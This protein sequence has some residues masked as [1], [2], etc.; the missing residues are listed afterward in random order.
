M[1]T[2]CGVALVACLM[3]F[4]GCAAIKNGSDCGNRWNGFCN[5][6][7]CGGGSG[8]RGGGFHLPSLGLNRGELLGR[9]AAAC[10]DGANANFSDY[11]YD[12]GPM[13]GAY[14]DSAQ[15]SNGCGCDSCEVG[16]SYVAGQWKSWMGNGVTVPR[17]FGGALAARAEGAAALLGSCRGLGATVGCMGCRECGGSNAIGTNHSDCSNSSG[18]CDTGCGPDGCGAIG[19]GAGLAGRVK[20]F[21]FRPN[22]SPHPYGGELPHTGA[23]A[24][25]NGFGGN[26]APTYAYPYYTTRGPRDFLMKNP[27]TI[28]R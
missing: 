20:G 16:Q 13:C 27:P 11:N 28:G 7:D 10:D 12:C 21:F 15:T 1:R 8:L 4:T 24:Q 19:G 22:G 23:P 17:P 5:E 14:L 26:A 25:G 2:I 6:G 3:I 9:G 18:G